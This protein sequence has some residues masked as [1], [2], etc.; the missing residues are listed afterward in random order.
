MENFTRLK[1]YF[2]RSIKNMIQVSSQIATF[3]HYLYLLF[4]NCMH[5]E[6][7]TNFEGS[8]MF[9]KMKN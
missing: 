5:I 6:K 3:L 7:L 1:I 2:N 8:V 9:K 4:E